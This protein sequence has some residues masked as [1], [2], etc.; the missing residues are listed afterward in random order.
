MSKYANLTEKTIVRDLLKHLKAKGFTVKSV[1]DVED[2]IPVKTIPDAIKVVF[3]VDIA[4][5]YFNEKSAG[6]VVLVSGN[7]EDI[8]SDW[9]YYE[10]GD[11]FDAAMEEFSATMD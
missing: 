2:N 5:V 4:R 3:D 8:I 1:Y 10:K 6:S 7:G 11:A 9:S